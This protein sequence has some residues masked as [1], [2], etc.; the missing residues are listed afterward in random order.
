M[1][2]SKQRLR[3]V[4]ALK[5]AAVKRIQSDIEELDVSTTRKYIHQFNKEFDTF[6]SVCEPGAILE[7]ARSADL[8]WIADYH[9]LSKSQIYAA[10]FVR[11]LAVNN[12]NII[13]A[14]EPVF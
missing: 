2:Y 5:R 14:V 13:L 7:E 3:E 11:E 4:T 8:I 1:T 12:S 9:A 6:Q 10:Q